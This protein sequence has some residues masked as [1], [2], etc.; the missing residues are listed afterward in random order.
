MNADDASTLRY[1]SING[2]QS[3][4]CS[5]AGFFGGKKRLKNMLLGFFIHSD[6]RVGNGQYNVGAW[7]EE[8]HT[9]RLTF[10][11]S[12]AGSFDQEHS[13]FGHRISGIDNQV[14]DDL[15][16]LALVRLDAADCGIEVRSQID[17]R[18]YQPL[19]HFSHIRYQKIQG[20]DVGLKNLL[21]AEGQQ[22]LCSSRGA[23][24][25]LQNYPGALTE[26]IAVR[27]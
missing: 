26:G 2:R 24:R 15:F 21:A 20:Q 8:R 11:Q 12:H 23:L 9:A 19:Q 4:S 22:L 18:A 6:A 13:A 14:H 25:S 10:S 3:Q 5:L 16:D 1:D 17:M 27:W 7:Q